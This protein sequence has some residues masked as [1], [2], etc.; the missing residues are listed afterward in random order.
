[1]AIAVRYTSPSH[2]F[3]IEHPIPSDPPSTGL[4]GLRQAILAT[5]KSLNIFLTDRKLEEDRANGVVNRPG[6][7]RKAGDDE[8]VVDEEG[9]NDDEEE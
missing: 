4:E 9:D 5:Q 6:T 8:D 7:K 1:M 3:N 2:T